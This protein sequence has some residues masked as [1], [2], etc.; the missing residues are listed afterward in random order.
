ML[1][2]FRLDIKGQVQGVGFR[3]LVYKL[4]NE[5]ALS[6]SVCNNGQGV[7]LTLVANQ[8]QLDTFIDRLKSSLPPLASIDDI[9]T[10]A[11]T[12]LS[13]ES[14]FSITASDH[15]QISTE[16]AADAATCLDCLEDIFSPENRRYLYPFTNCTNCGPRYSIIRQLPYDRP[17]TTMAEFEICD[18]CQREYQDPADRRF[19][20][21]PNACPDC[22]PQVKLYDSCGAAILDPDPIAHTVSLLKQGKIVAIKGIGGYHLACDA[23]NKQAVERLREKKLR[24]SKPL[25]LM[26]AN[27]ASLQHLVEI[28]P[29]AKQYLTSSQAP[30]VLAR[31]AT[32]DFNHIAPGLNWLG[33]MLP[34]TPLHYLLFHQAM[35][36]PN[37]TDW[38]KNTVPLT[39]VMTSANPKGQPLIY[40]EDQLPQLL[41]LA[42]YVLTHNRQIERRIDDAIVNC[43]TETPIIIRRGRGMAPKAIALTKD[44]RPS[45]ALGGFFKNSI[46]LT[47]GNKAYLSQYIGDLNNPD[48][49][50]YL[51]QTVEHMMQV[52]DI[53]PEQVFCDLHPDFYS[54]QFAEQFANKH[55]L[56]LT[57]IQHHFAHVAAIAC[58]HQLTEPY[59]ALAL[60][61]VGLGDDGLSWGGELLKVNQGNYQRQGHLKPMC[62]PGGDTA[63]KEP[64]RIAL[65]FLLEQGLT[66]LAQT[67]YQHLS[68]YQIVKQMIARKV[69][70]PATSSC[71]RLFDLAASLLGL[72]DNNSYEAESAM[73]LESA[74]MGVEHPD[75]EPLFHIS[76]SRQLD[77]T[78]LLIRLPKM[79]ASQ[80]AALF[81]QQLVLALCCWLES[82][83]EQES[84]NIVLS[85]GCFL[86]A[87]LVNKLKAELEQK[88]FNVFIAKQLPPN[89]SSLALGQAWIGTNLRS[90]LCV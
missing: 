80:G 84:R 43:V 59:L 85:G 42:D 64:W 51:Q 62:L 47:R 5:M 75:E 6:G 31:K 4:A 63:A 35:G 20:A 66:E 79:E 38:L 67:K 24:K 16:I 17:F 23:A 27:L 65:S 54:S 61:G 11:L 26:A 88:N 78:S 46:C 70:C 34:Y 41:S 55:Q 21:Q 49:C 37:G 73:R 86:N 15:T 25:S 40:D 56:P 39:L 33:V 7:E 2:G 52:F 45:L 57:R 89:D 83:A 1:S 71:G 58:E 12:G 72:S 74:A 36:R 29:T 3:P 53:Q 19:H 48:N 30:I 60:D 8:A 90:N 87:R 44:T 81:H 82:V 18:A 32:Q 50:R 28:N 68:G 13:S 10:S 9:S 22:G 14:G 77:F 76:N 69:N